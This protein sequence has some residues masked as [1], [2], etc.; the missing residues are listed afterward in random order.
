VGEGK[1]TSK[2]ISDAVGVSDEDS[3]NMA[4]AH[5]TASDMGIK[6]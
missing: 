6:E 3:W 4:V 1:G 5:A 2:S